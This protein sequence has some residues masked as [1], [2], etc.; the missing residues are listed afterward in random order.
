MKILTVVDKEK[1]A[2]HRLALGVQKYNP[3]LNIEILAVHPKRPDN[4]QLLKYKELAEWADILDFQYWKTALML[5]ERFPEFKRKKKL[6]THHNPYSIWENDWQ[7]F[8]GLIV[9]NQE[10]KSLLP[11]AKLI[12]LAIDLN[13]FK[14]N[15]DYT[16]E[17]TVGMVVARI[18]GK[19][20]ILPVA[21]VCKEL[22]YKMILVGRVSD[23]NYLNEVL[24]TG[25]VDF[26][27]D[28]SEEEL[29]DAYKEM[30]VYVFNS[31]DNFEAGSLPVLE[32]MATGVPVLARRIGHIPEL[33]DGMNMVV[34]EGQ[35]DDLDDLKESLKNL[36]ED[37]EKRIELREKG[38]KTV[39]TRSDEIRAR[40]YSKIYHKI[41]SKSTLVSVIVPTFN[42][43]D[44]LAKALDG[45]FRQDYPSFEIV[46]A[47]DGSTD[48]TKEMVMEKRK[49]SF[50]P[51]KYVNTNDTNQ[52]HLA[53]ARNMAAIEAE[54]DILVFMD[55]RFYPNKNM[56]SEF[57]KRL[58]SG[59]FLHGNKGSGKRTFV[60]NF[61][62]IYRQEF[63]NAGMFCERI[64]Q[65]GGLTQETQKRFQRQGFR[66]LYVDSAQAR[67]I[68]SSHS[69]WTR[70][71]EIMRS[72]IILQKMGM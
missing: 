45:L 3:H 33:Y 66:F 63:I 19:K 61:S 1:S 51:I 52:Y 40:E 72:K 55:D 10:Q 18:E 14:W 26:R 21:Q 5:L 6:L 12:P 24:R 67:Q 37:K 64:E 16:E 65:Y 68:I 69:K 13:F 48:G 46:V 58:Y 8:D 17:K 34:R 62:C 4:S 47:D 25:V 59:Y 53:K 57:V 7:D 32:A 20:G 44:V 11:N 71:E 22:G 15:P 54:G 41:W 50:V 39:I 56:I 70:K 31:V 28:V 35:P 27:N 60:E 23:L 49:K 9:V 30:A 42:R 38:W 36:M 2:I 43:K 29:K